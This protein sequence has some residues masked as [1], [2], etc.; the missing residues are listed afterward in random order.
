M[1]SFKDK[2]FNTYDCELN[3]YRAK[4]VGSHPTSSRSGRNQ[5]LE[6]A[7][8]KLSV[9]PIELSGPHRDRFRNF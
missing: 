5:N 8:C 7:A 2:I 3:W 1:L 6:S 9:L 4:S